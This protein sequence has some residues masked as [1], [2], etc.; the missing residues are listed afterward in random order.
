ME[1]A[2][3]EFEK[4]QWEVREHQEW[5]KRMEEEEVAWKAE[6]EKKRKVKEEDLTD[7]KSRVSTELL[8]CSFIMFFFQ[9]PSRLS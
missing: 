5:Q 7:R 9:H 3:L 8:R 1:K 4:M 6:A 2:C